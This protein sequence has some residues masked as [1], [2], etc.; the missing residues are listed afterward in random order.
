VVAEKQLDRAVVRPHGSI[1][2]ADVPVPGFRHL[3]ADGG[4]QL[5]I[6]FE[7]VEVAVRELRDE[8]PQ[9]DPEV[10]TTVD[11]G[12]ARLTGLFYSGETVLK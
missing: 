9:D 8:L 7:S 4:V 2:H 6:G 5:S 10:G 12:L 1:G 3:P 11:E